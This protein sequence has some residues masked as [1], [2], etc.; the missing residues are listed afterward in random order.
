MLRQRKVRVVLVLVCL[1]RKSHL[2]W[3]EPAAAPVCPASPS[4]R[5]VTETLV[6]STALDVRGVRRSNAK[7]ATQKT[8]VVERRIPAQFIGDV[9]PAKE[10]KSGSCKSKRRTRSSLF[11]TF[12]INLYNFNDLR[13]MEGHPHELSL[14]RNMGRIIPFSTVF[15]PILC[16]NKLC[17]PKFSGRKFYF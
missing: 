14:I 13:G 15:F 16:K 2:P 5:P 9:P 12:V 4:P 17:F 3:F 6:I 8:D 10:S 7:I 1:C 11:V